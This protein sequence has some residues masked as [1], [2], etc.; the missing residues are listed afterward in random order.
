MVVALIGQAASLVM[1]PRLTG[2]TTALLYGVRLVWIPDDFDFGGRL[3]ESA[4]LVMVFAF[5]TWLPAILG[6]T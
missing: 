5:G 2:T 1:A 6:I 3:I 4:G